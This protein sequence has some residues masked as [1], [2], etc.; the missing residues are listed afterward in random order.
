MER[1]EKILNKAKEL[2]KELKP[3]TYR[4]RK[5]VLEFLKQ[6]IDVDGWIDNSRR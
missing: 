6:L 5:M 3:L 4:E 2:M 1:E